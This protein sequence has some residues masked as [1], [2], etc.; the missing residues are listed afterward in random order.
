[1]RCEQMFH[2]WR[3]LKIH[4]KSHLAT[5]KEIRMLQKGHVPDETKMGVEFRGKNRIIVS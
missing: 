4:S 5:L 3:A 2:S 1:M